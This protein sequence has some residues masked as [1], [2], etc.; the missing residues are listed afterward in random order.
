MNIN[1]VFP[2]KY[3]KAS[4]LQD[5][6]VRVTIKDVQLEKVGED[7]KPVLYFQG[8]NKKGL[9]MNKTNCNAVAMVYG[10][11]TDDWIDAE[12]ELFPTMVDFQGE[13]RPAIRISVPPITRSAR[14]APAAD[15]FA[16]QQ[17]VQARQAVPSAGYAAAKNGDMDDEIPF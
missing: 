9:V 16:N 7:Q 3:I 6:K 5:R 15:P 8:K 11:N 17:S 14:P 1:E 10:A 4:D 13:S 2:S 12:V